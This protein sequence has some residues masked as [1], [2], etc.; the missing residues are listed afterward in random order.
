MLFHYGS[1]P[2]TPPHPSTTVVTSPNAGPWGPTPRS[3]NPAANVTPPTPAPGVV[4]TCQWPGVRYLHASADGQPAC[5]DP[6]AAQPVAVADDCDAFLC[7]ACYG[8]IA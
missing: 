2:D 3:Y 4:C 7:R 8:D 5:G 1:R 6:A